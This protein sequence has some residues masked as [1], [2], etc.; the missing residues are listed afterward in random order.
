MKTRGKG[1]ILQRGWHEKSPA[2]IESGEIGPPEGYFMPEH[3][4]PQ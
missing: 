1:V 2:Q 3:N 4:G